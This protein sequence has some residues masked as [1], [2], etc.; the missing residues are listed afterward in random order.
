VR[1]A[2]LL[3]AAR[4]VPDGPPD[5]DPIVLRV[6]HD[7]RTVAPGDL[8][9]CVPGGVHDGHRFAADAV[10]RGAVA[11]LAER[12]L[13][14]SE[15]PDVPV[16]MVPSV[17][18][19]MGP[20]AAAARGWPS[21]DLD[22]AG[23]TG[24]NGKTSVVHLLRSILTSTGRQA[25]SWGTLS[26]ARTTPEGPDL[27]ATLAG[28][29]TDGVEAAAIEVSSH[30]LAQHRVDG[31]TFTAIGF[32]TLGRDHLDFHGSMAAYE[33]AKARLFDGSFSDHA[34]VAVDGPAGA[35]MAAL[36]ESTGLSVVRVYPAVAEATVSAD[37]CTLRW[38]GRT[39]RLAT[40]GRF[41]VA[42]ALVA[43]ELAV[44]LGCGEADVVAGLADAP[45]VPGRFQP[46][47]LDGGPAVLVD[48]AHTPDA[49]AAVLAAAREVLE[50]ERAG[51]STLGGSVLSAGSTPS[52]GSASGRLIVVFGCGGERDLG[53]R[54]LM[55]RAA[56]G[57]A[58]L[59]VVTSD[60]PRGEPPAW[61]IADILAGMERSDPLVEPDRRRAISAALV[62]AGPG[63]LVVV[64]GRGHEATQEVAGR[65][66][67]FD[68][69]TV[70]VEEWR[71]LRDGAD[72]PDGGGD[73]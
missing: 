28:W 71:K 17:R 26:G 35:R 47:L 13:V 69:R 40:G 7:S 72:R 6:T 51:R 39:V 14:G 27:Q 54:P 9:C 62:A 22:L 24:T 63:D 16:V 31:T 66:V 44:V 34:V 8:F 11:V 48:Y 32:T 18:V 29:V 1:L 49:L 37:G 23:V 4:V 38:R 55:G 57:A 33:A 58:D 20:L 70:V 15:L 52:A 19:S 43:A 67:P 73:R 41:T 56:E 65:H 12:P 64:A 25:D 30:A 5:A 61:V 36:A 42:N 10:G 50:G 60:N 3:T 46:V 68:D 59:A 53:K 45:P 2:A 21:R